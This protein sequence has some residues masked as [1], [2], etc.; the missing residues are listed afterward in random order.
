LAHLLPQL[1]AEP[2]G[3]MDHFSYLI[4]R[5]H[6]FLL[7]GIFVLVIAVASTVTGEGIEPRRRMV[8]RADEP[9]RFWTIVAWWYSVGFLFIGFFCYQTQN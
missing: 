6:R 3:Q 4:D 1:A 9:K 7:I 5:H 2:R 8:H